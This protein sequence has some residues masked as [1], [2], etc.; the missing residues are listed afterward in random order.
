MAATP[1]LQTS[2]TPAQATAFPIVLFSLM[3]IGG[4]LVWNFK[5]KNS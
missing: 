3:G 4:L 5:R 1:A 2:A